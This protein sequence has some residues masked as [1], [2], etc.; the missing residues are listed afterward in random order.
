MAVVQYRCTVLNMS[1]IYNQDLTR[2][3]KVALNVKV[4][5]LHLEKNPLFGC[6]GFWPVKTWKETMCENGPLMVDTSNIENFNL[7]RD[8][9]HILGM[10]VKVGASKI[11]PENK[12]VDLQ[13]AFIQGI[14]E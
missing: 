12:K 1:N 10:T 6:C 8:S 9:G 7:Y 2:L 11:G 3:L 5:A 14:N 13:T 4:E